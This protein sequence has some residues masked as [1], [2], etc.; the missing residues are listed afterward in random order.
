VILSI[1]AGGLRRLFER[2]GEEP[3]EQ[4]V[5]LV[6]MSIRRP[7]E[8]LELGNRVAT[9]MVSLPLS[10]GDPRRRLESAGGHHHRAERV[11][12]PR[13]D[14]DRVDHHDD[15]RDDEHLV[16]HH[17]DDALGLRWLTSDVVAGPQTCSRHGWTHRRRVQVSCLPRPRDTRSPS[18]CSATT[19]GVF[20]LAGDATF[21][22]IDEVAGDSRRRWRAARGGGL[23]TPPTAG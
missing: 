16:H 19:R 6:P 17:N 13:P 9:L 15:D 3:P 11:D 12:R 10:E 23:A 14:D 22:D 2:R 21:A 7:D 18:A 4:L 20:G 5:A 8:H 1:A